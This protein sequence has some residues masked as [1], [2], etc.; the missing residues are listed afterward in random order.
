MYSEYLERYISAFADIGLTLDD[1]MRKG[2]ARIAEI[3]GLD[4]EEVLKYAE[5]RFEQSACAEGVEAKYE[6]APIDDEVVVVNS[7][8]FKELRE[9]ESQGYDVLEV[10]DHSM[11]FA[12]VLV[13][14]YNNNANQWGFSEMVWSD[15]FLYNHILYLKR[16]L[17]TFDDY[18][19]NRGEGF[20]MI[21]HGYRNGYM[22]A[23]IDTINIVCNPFKYKEES[24]KTVQ[25]PIGEK[26][27]APKVEANLCSTTKPDKQKKCPQEETEKRNKS[28]K[29]SQLVVPKNAV[30]QVCKL[31]DG[32]NQKAEKWGYDLLTFDANTFTISGKFT[33]KSSSSGLG[34]AFKEGW[35]NGDLGERWKQILKLCGKGGA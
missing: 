34:S 13:H 35:R 32:Y 17:Q 19:T 25:K 16:E 14:C 9:Y 31:I 30:S 22:E 26:T 33:P 27:T 3:E 23:I 29:Q 28:A 10:P 21:E 11:G 8:Q 4:K 2:I 6:L 12:A 20:D 15:V 24:N 7:I 18:V 5:Q 1:E